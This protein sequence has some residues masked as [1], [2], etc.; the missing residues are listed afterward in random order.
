MEAEDCYV[1]LLYYQ[2]VHIPCPEQI[3]ESQLELCKRLD[4]HGRIR[5]SPEGLNGTL[6]GT[7]CAIDAYVAAVDA[8]KVLSP[9]QIHWKFGETVKSKRIHS[10]SVKVC[11]EVVSMDLSPEVEASLSNY[12]PGAHLAPE[13]FHFALQREAAAA[14]GAG[15]DSANAHPPGHKEAIV[16]DVRNIYETRIGRFEVEPD[17][18]IIDPQSR[19]FS[20][21]AVFVDANKER[22][23]DKTVYMYCTGGVRCEKASRYIR[24]MGVTDNIYQ[25]YGGIHN[26]QATFPNGGFFRGKN[27]VFDPRISV[28]SALKPDEVVGS[29]CLCNQ[30]F[31]DYSAKTRCSVCRI[32]VLVCDPCREAHTTALKELKTKAEDV[33][34][35][36][37]SPAS[38]ATTAPTSTTTPS[39]VLLPPNLLCEQC[40][41]DGREAPG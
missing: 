28:P 34:T 6:D 36:A 15:A 32:L 31:D 1:T 27:F 5:I 12:T 30:A 10:A 41:K 11:K 19:S 37:T 26:Y 13:D 3:C 7:K 21:F 33:D 38:A 24:S 40:T 17:L 4:L 18:E 20:D 25:L 39:T 22:L 35:S 14:A 9:T 29:C 8:D 2:Y 16:I 23:A